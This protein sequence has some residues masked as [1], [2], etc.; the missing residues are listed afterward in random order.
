M[1]K[2]E[3]MDP[4][5]REIGWCRFNFPCCTGYS[6][7]K[8]YRGI[9]LLIHKYPNDFRPHCLRPILLFDIEA[10]IHNKHLGKLTIKTAGDLNVLS[11]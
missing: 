10:Y 7:K 5:I 3:V 1:V 8:Y 9:D 11:P 4:E 6:N 2:T